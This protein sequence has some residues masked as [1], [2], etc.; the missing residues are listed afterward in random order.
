MTEKHGIGITPLF[1]AFV[2]LASAG[3]V[4]AAGCNN[5]AGEIPAELGQEITLQLGQTAYIKDANIKFKFAD[6]TGDSRCPT[7]AT[8][9]WQG[10]VTCILEIIYLGES[11]SMTIVQPGLTDTPGE[12]TF[13]EYNIAYSVE[14]YPEVGRDIKDDEYR[15]KLVFDKK[16]L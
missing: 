11:Y 4:F 9:I 13:R 2:L 3:M 14:P 12:A 15:L 6:M 10:E 1:L 7:G 8:C 5:Q 16:P